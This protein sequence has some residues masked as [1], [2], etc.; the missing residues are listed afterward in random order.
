[1]P[2][3]STQR[4][5]AE[6]TM[7]AQWPRHS[8]VVSAASLALRRGLGAAS[9]FRAGLRLAS[10]AWEGNAVQQPGEGRA[11]HG[12]EREVRRARQGGRG[13]G[14]EGV[15]GERGAAAGGGMRGTP[16]G[17]GRGPRSAGRGAPQPGGEACPGNGRCG[18]GGARPRTRAA[19]GSGE[20]GGPQAPGVKKG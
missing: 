14:G 4:W 1:E 11:A 20:R 5:S 15:G 6:T 9:L 13:G 17:E 3:Y 18:P 8:T 12:A 10:R 7:R 2:S 16:G 19:T